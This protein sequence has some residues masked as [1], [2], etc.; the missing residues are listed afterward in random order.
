MAATRMI[1]VRWIK[2]GRPLDLDA[3]DAVI[4]YSGSPVT[5]KMR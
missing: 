5:V 1:R 3:A 2:A 4:T